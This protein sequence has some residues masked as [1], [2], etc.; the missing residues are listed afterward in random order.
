LEQ[1]QRLQLLMPEA[2]RERLRTLQRFLGFLCEFVEL[3]RHEKN[4]FPAAYVPVRL[5]VFQNGKDARR[6]FRRTRRCGTGLVGG[7]S[8]DGPASG[9]EKKPARQNPIGFFTHSIWGDRITSS[10]T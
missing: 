4:S 6:E 3:K 2:L 1:V 10:Q 7:K 9:E 8:G 5:S